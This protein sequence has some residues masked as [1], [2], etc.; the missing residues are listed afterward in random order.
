MVERLKD[1]D[2]SPPVLE[3]IYL[4]HAGID[5][6]K[7]AGKGTPWESK[8]IYLGDPPKKGEDA[9]HRPSVTLVERYQPFDPRSKTPQSV[10]CTLVYR[11]TKDDQDARKTVDF[12]LIRDKQNKD[13]C[14]WEMKNVQYDRPLPDE[15]RK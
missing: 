4:D 11:T 7:A 13:A 1:E 2:F 9:S 3:K 12:A 5:T 8:P 10:H 14:P 15:K 6:T